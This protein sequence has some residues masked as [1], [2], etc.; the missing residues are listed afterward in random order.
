MPCRKQG[1]GNFHGTPEHLLL[2]LLS[3]LGFTL[4]AFPTRAPRTAAV[5]GTPTQRL[6][7]AV[8]EVMTSGNRQGPQD[9]HLPPP[10]DSRQT[11][12]T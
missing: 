5:P 3:R 7:G 1:N 6:G 8:R 4:P 9:T 12:P 2:L 10:S 11:A